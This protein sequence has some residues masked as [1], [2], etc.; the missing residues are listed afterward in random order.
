MVAFSLK[1]AAVAVSFAA[2]A[3]A[4][5]FQR[6]GT[7]PTLGCILPPDAQDFLAGQYFDIRVEIHAPV[8]GS[9]ATDGKPHSEQPTTVSLRAP[10][11]QWVPKS[12]NIH[13][14]DFNR[15][16][17]RRLLSDHREAW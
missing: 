3:S 15:Q 12:R 9:E 4:Q 2:A 10:T 16:S 17:R 5:T 8:N 7:C 13:A 14:N 11:S 6:L 1:S